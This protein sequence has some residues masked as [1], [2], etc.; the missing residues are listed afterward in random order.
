[1]TTEA[2]DL[3]VSLTGAESEVIGDAERAAGMRS[4]GR[5]R[6]FRFGIGRPHEPVQGQGVVEGLSR[7]SLGSGE[8]LLLP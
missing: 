6:S 8:R 5:R 1:M 3:W 2:V 7:K 4:D